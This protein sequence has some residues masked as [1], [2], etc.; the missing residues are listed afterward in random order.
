MVVMVETMTVPVYRMVCVY[1]GTTQDARV[2]MVIANNKQ[3]RLGFGKL[4]WRGEDGTR[5]M[6]GNI[7]DIYMETLQ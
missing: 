7:G 1:I 2:C 6:G 3:S 5:T 4:S